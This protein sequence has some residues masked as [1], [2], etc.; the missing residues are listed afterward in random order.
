MDTGW[1][2]ADVEH[3]FRKHAESKGV[4][5]NPKKPL[6]ALDKGAIKR[7]SELLGSKTWADFAEVAGLAAGHFVAESTVKQWS[8]DIGRLTVEST[9]FPALCD[10]AARPYS[11]HREAYENSAWLPLYIEE[12]VAYA[13]TNTT[14]PPEDAAAALNNAWNRCNIASLLLAAF[15]LPS[16]DLES[17]AHLA[18]RM[19]T[20]SPSNASITVGKPYPS[21]DPMR[22]LDEAARLVQEAESMEREAINRVPSQ[23]VASVDFD[24][25]RAFVEERATISSQFH[26]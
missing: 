22:T 26:A 13:L 24:Q 12:C 9:I 15:T 10:V 20:A 2:F 8:N 16:D 21:S 23:S 7:A 6:A 25:L 3:I 1:Q 19:L 4:A 11:E 17:L 5:Y 14:E 18:K